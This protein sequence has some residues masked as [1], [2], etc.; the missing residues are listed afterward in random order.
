[1]IVSFDFDHTLSRPDVQKYAKELIQKGI[2]VWVITARYDDLHTHLYINNTGCDPHWNN[3]DLWEVVEN[4]NLPKNRVRFMNMVPKYMFLS[5][6]KVIWHLDDNF[7]EL[8]CI[9][10][11]GISTKGIDVTKNGWKRECNK[12]LKTKK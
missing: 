12:L 10:D 7:D 8:S 4:I 3:D 1:M 6:T 9:L 2:D 11:S 5:N